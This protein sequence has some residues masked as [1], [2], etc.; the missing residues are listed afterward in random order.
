MDPVSPAPT[1]QPNQEPTPVPPA[2]PATPTPAQPTVTP[3]AQASEPV[4]QAP[5]SD[6]SFVTAASPQVISPDATPQPA[7]APVQPQATPAFGYT[8]PV[9]TPAQPVMSFNSQK[10]SKKPLGL[11]AG[12]IA[13]VLLLSSGVVFGYVL[14]NRPENVWSTGMN[15]SGKALEKLVSTAT[16]KTT[17]DKFTKSQVTA[18]LTADM[19]AEKFSGTLTSKYDETGANGNLVIK[20]KNTAGEEKEISLDAISKVIKDSTY[21]TAYIRFKGLS[22]L[23]LDA[24]APGIGAF[25]NKWITIDE[26]YFKNLGLEDGDT[27]K[28]QASA[29]DYAKL[30]NAAMEVTNEYIFTAAEDKAVFTRKSFVAKEKVDDV[31]AF[32][33]TVGV[34]VDHLADYCKALVTKEMGMAEFKKLPLYN[35]DTFEEDKK[36]ALKDCD[37]IKTDNDNLAD[38]TFDMWIDAKYKLVYKIRLTDKDT[39]DSYVDIGQLYRGGDDVNLFMKNHDKDVDASVVFKTNIKTSLTSLDVNIK[40]KTSGEDYDVTINLAAKPYTGEVDTK[41]PDGAIKIQDVLNQLGL[42][43]GSFGGSSSFED[44]STSSSSQSTSAD[45]EN[46][47]KLNNLYSKLE[48]YYNE[49]ATYP[50][51]SNLASSSWRSTNLPGLSNSSSYSIVS[52]STTPGVMIYVGSSCTATGCLHYSLSTETS[53]SLYTKNSLN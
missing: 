19:G 36:S 29:D 2:A 34:Q 28:S 31:S 40:G 22:D 20:A 27:P 39:K 17:I 50:T 18:S 14:P 26:D 51:L 13:A 24:F 15:R 7:A 35:A 10:K 32:H 8:P 9:T 41:A 21:P 47:V 46:K 1:P 30:A 38:E 43:G 44:N 33:Y 16:E 52:S 48:E 3:P 45:I 37:D 5:V 42:N 49:N 25:E 11:I 23:G 53:T 6:M 12:G 4:A